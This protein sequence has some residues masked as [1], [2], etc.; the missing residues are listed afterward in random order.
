MT[1]LKSSGG[2]GTAQRRPEG[3]IEA[4]ERLQEEQKTAAY[5]FTNATDGIESLR[6]LC[7]YYGW[8]TDGPIATVSV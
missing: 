2:K 1:K 3:I 6:A 8:P 5:R 4:L 7:L